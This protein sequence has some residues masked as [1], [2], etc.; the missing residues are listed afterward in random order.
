MF[1]KQHQSN[2]LQD[3]PNTSTERHN[4]GK[5]RLIAWVSG[6]ITVT[7]ILFVMALPQ[8]SANVSAAFIQGPGQF[9]SA[10]IAQPASPAAPEVACTTFSY[11]PAANF[12]AGTNP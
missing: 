8:A 10:P 2:R 1:R 9:A 12:G 7:A 3:N 11:A 5:Y 4:P 6:L